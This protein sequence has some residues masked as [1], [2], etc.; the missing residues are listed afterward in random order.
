M[1]KPATTSAPWASF[2]GVRRVTAEYR[3]FLRNSQGSKTPHIFDLTTVNDNILCWRFRVK[4]FDEDVQAGQQLNNDLREM[5]RL[6]GQDNILM[7]V[8]FPEDYPTNPFFMRVVSPRCVMYTGHVTAGGS[9]CIEAL[10]PTGGP[11]G[12][13]SD[14]SVEGIL[15]LVL[16]NMLHAE[17]TI[18][19]TATGPGGISGPLRVDMSRGRACLYE[20]SIAE[21]QAAYGRTVANHGWS[22]GSGSGSGRTAAA[23][24]LPGTA[25]P[26]LAGKAASGPCP[27]KRQ[28]AT[29]GK[30]GVVGS[31]AAAAPAWA[32]ALA[33]PAATGQAP[34]HRTRART[35]AAMQPA[36]GTSATAATAPLIA[37]AAAAAAAAGGFNNAAATSAR[38]R[39]AAITEP[40]C[41][42]VDK[43]PGAGAGGQAAAANASRGPG[44]SARPEIITIDD[45]DDDDDD[46]IGGGGCSSRHQVAP[47]R[48]KQARPQ[49]AAPAAAAARKRHREADDD[50]A[51]I[52]DGAGATGA[53]DTAP[54][55][56]R[57]RAANAAA[58]QQPPA[59][60]NKQRQGRGG[61]SGGDGRA[62]ADADGR[63]GMFVDM[64]N[65]VSSG[66]GRWTT[67]RGAA[68]Q[69]R[70]R[71]A[72]AG[73]GAAADGKVGIVDLTV[74]P[75]GGVQMQSMRLS[76]RPRARE[77]SGAAG[78]AGA[79]A[80]GGG[81]AA[82]AA[83]VAMFTGGAVDADAIAEVAAAAAA[84][85]QAAADAALA[86]LT[87]QL[88]EAKAKLEQEQR[89]KKRMEEK[90]QELAA[91]ALLVKG[92]GASSSAGPSAADGTSTAAA[93]HASSVLLSA[94]PP[95]HWEP[96]RKEEGFGVKMVVLPLKG[97]PLAG[98]SSL[99]AAESSGLPA[100]APLN[101]VD[102]QTL[103]SNGLSQSDAEDLLRHCNG[104]LDEALTLAFE[105]ADYGGI[106]ALLNRQRQAAAA[107]AAGGSTDAA[108]KAAALQAELESVLARFEKASG[109][110]RSRVV[111]VERVQN[112][113]LWTKYCMRSSEIEARVRDSAAAGPSTSNGLIHGRGGNEYLMWH[114]TSNRVVEMVV[115]DG[116]D[117]RESNRAGALGEGIYFAANANYSIA[118]THRGQNP[119]LG[120]KPKREP[121][122]SMTFPGTSGAMM[123]CR[124]ALGTMAPGGSGIRKPPP[125]ADSVYMSNT[126]QPSVMAAAAAP[127]QGR[128][129]AVGGPKAVSAQAAGAGGGSG[130]TAAPPVDP[131]WDVG[132]ALGDNLIVAVFD[133]AQAYP[134]YV[135]H[136]N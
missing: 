86:A 66:L 94:A 78:Q 2:S 91:Q 127:W 27:P 50:D 34:A 51:L 31:G 119:G 40:S 33:P 134:E 72:Q 44:P 30:P 70:Q 63:S 67:R 62:A 68:G 103:V 37:A 120:P 36:A 106:M 41:A 118:Y 20:Y 126:V 8:N 96:L 10:V 64:V 1:A 97:D 76:K 47:G 43:R 108:A 135:V 15:V 123:L 129:W 93:R 111:R 22:I 7:E 90:M 11:G 105:A 69:P 125:G 99:A 100:P 13:R 26:S 16:A 112:W 53:A 95:P 6:F 131:A 39:I 82:G 38:R 132:S 128:R 89:A 92:P 114:G 124:V 23:L 109:L 54:S 14:Y 83:A 4:D 74:A 57:G 49:Q 117:S 21:A 85:A 121:A 110:S 71:D 81:S 9:I 59:V 60:S 52:V 56:D 42:V 17:V 28:Q 115:K 58:A 32:A 73:A 45:D 18:V 107:A 24:S 19:R 80:A 35:A 61:G 102:V 55:R 116:F 29:D 98:T 77:R 46:D 122:L 5:G 130:A 12:W 65:L 104:H 88:E 48:R 84:E 25:M 136:F 75:A 133:N 79:A 3:A 101:D 113:R 87:A